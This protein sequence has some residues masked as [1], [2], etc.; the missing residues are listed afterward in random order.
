MDTQRL[1]LLFIFLFSGWM[2]FDKW[3]SAHRPPAP[4][5]PATQPGAA[6]AATDVPATPPTK[7]AAAQAAPPGAPGA[8]PA[9]A[10]KVI[11]LTTDLFRVQVDTAGG[12]I[13]EV[14]LLKQRDTAD[15]AKPYLA[16]QHT[17]ERISIAQ[18][19]LL[20][21]GMPNHRTLWE[22]V[23]GPRELA[24]GAD[25]VSLVLE[26]T[27]QNG[28][29][30]RQILTFHRGSYVIDVAFEITNAGTAPISPYAYF[31]LV[32]DAKSPGT[33]SST[34]KPPIPTGSRRS[35]RTPTTAGSR[36]SSTTSSR[37]GCLLTT[38]SSRASSMR[39]GST[40]ASMPRA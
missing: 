16:L 19:G 18:S 12:V 22:A 36:W 7:A 26:A 29:K 21:E 8:V 13:Q 35:R 11:T 2:L 6:P 38:R 9:P 37:H 33:Q 23:P 5:A 28:D 24:A 1:I 25:S 30:V 40:P 27:A 14:A 4:V 39:G 17:P 31:Q 10:G 34:R 20:G 32:R 15:E 3:Q